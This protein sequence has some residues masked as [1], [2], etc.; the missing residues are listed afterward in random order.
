MNRA[1]WA[2]GLRNP[3]TFAFQPGSGRMFIN[4]VGQNTTEEI[5]DGIAGSNYGWP[6]SEG[7]TTN[8]AH[9]GP[10]L[11]LRA[12]HQRH[13]GLR[14]HRRRVLQPATVQSSP[15]PTSAQY[16]FAD[17]CS[18]WIRALRSGRRHAPPA[19]RPGSRA[20]WTCRSPPTAASTTSSA[21]PARS[22]GSSSRRTRRREI[23]AHPAEPDRLRRP[24]GLLQRGRLR[25][26]AA[27]ATSGSATASTSPGATA[28][29]YTLATTALADDGATF[30]RW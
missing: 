15:P 13:D 2:L 16:F 25:H 29:T 6:E 4:D 27:A 5:N 3:F 22:G 10:A 30:R 26:R 28:S 21:A 12:R 9:R 20:R 11:L 17:F 19:S 18:G 7:P 14:D 1:I 24:A 23:T 8:P